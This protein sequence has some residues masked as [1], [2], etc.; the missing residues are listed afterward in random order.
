MHDK[1]KQL[2]ADHAAKGDIRSGATLKR[3]VEIFD[4]VGQGYVS[5]T[6]DAIA[7]VSMQIEA[8]AMY[9]EGHLQLTSFMKRNL[10]DDKIFGACK[11][12]ISSG[13]I[14]ADV[15]LQ[16]TSVEG[17]L[18]RLKNLRRMSFTKPESIDQNFNEL[19]SVPVS[20]PK[21]IKNKGGRPAAEHWDDMWVAIAMQLYEGDLQPKRQADIEKAMMDC[22][23][24]A[25]HSAADSTVRKRARL[26]WQRIEAAEN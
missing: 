21:A 9:E 12:G 20:N 1:V 25:G 26:L 3:H 23:A 14:A 13:A 5:S 8:F 19:K 4:D 10:E 24:D 2:H 15:W 7:G 11:R 6:L 22:L 16:F 18:H 17:Q